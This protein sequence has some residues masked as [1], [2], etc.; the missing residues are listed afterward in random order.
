MR[1]LFL[2]MISFLHAKVALFTPPA[3][4]E[5]AQLKNPS[6]FVKIGFLGK[7]TGEFRPS[8]NLATEDDVDVSLK[9]YVKTV[10]ELQMAE[11]SSQVRDLG[12]F[13][14]QCGQGRLL[15]I[16]NSSPWGDIKVLQVL[17]VQEK[18]AYVLT[19]AVLKEDFLHF[20]KEILKSFRSLTLAD[21][22]FSQIADTQKRSTFLDFFSKLG[23][24]EK[25][26]SDWENLQ[27]QAS[28]FADLGPYWVFLL[29]QEGHAK[30]YSSGSSSP[31]SSK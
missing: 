9:E 15:E 21:D 30:I 2:L 29:L 26:D 27:K 16:T 18:K 6:P 17:F 10:K 13:P 5:I 28:Q 3:G 11:N 22:L 19:A 25:K 12:P 23:Q 24:S 20:Q 7:G 31:E 14:M 4:W 8:I 1:I